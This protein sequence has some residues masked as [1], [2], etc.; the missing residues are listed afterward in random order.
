MKE[1]G[2]ECFRSASTSRVG[3]PLESRF[4]ETR[5]PLSDPLVFYETDRLGPLSRSGSPSTARQRRPAGSRPPHNVTA[6]PPAARPRAFVARCGK[7]LE[8]R[9]FLPVL[10]TARV[11]STATYANPEARRRR[12]RRER[13]TATES[14]D[15]V[16]QS[17][18]SVR[19]SRR[20]S[21]TRAR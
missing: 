18:V 4:F 11:H 14:D 21:G 15:S 13:R 17:A 20:R 3:Y 7:V 9:V 8:R 5:S 6:H 19:R 1:S 2:F 16:S 12:V 10:P